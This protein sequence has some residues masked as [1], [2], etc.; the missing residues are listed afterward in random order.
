VAKKAPTAVRAYGFAHAAPRKRHPVRLAVILLVLV[1]IVVGGLLGAR[2][3]VH[4]QY[5]V[6]VR[7]AEVTVFR[8][9]PESV[10]GV[11]LSSVKESTGIPVA[12]LL[13]FWRDR[14]QDNITTG[15]LG[16]AQQIVS[17]LRANQLPPCAGTAPGTASTASTA[18]T[19]SAAAT[20]PA[21]VTAGPAPAATCAAGVK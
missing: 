13:P 11:N 3:Y 5:Y 19:A 15:S 14:V 4:T 20:V 8:G 1:A 16:G 12:G 9:V 17:E 7:N 6:G 18:A 2:A 21:P 10:A